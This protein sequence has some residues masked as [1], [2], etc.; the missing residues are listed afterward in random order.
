M[1]V[2]W[3]ARE[4]ARRLQWACAMRGGRLVVES[5]FAGLGQ[6]HRGGA[7]GLARKQ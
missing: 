4:L 2:S 1:S 3:S 5:G 7:I 6:C